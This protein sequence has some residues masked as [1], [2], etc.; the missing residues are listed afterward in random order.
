MAVTLKENQFT[1]T[2]ETTKKA[3][4][5]VKD[6]LN[7]QADH[8]RKRY[9]VDLVGIVSLAAELQTTNQTL[10]KWMCDNDVPLRDFT[11]ARAVRNQ[12]FLNSIHNNRDEILR[13]RTEEK[14]K[15]LAIAEALEVSPKAVG[16]VLL[17]ANLS[18]PLHKRPPKQPPERKP[19]RGL[20]R[21]YSFRTEV[22]AAIEEGMTVRQLAERFRVSEN[23]VSNWLRETGLQTCPA[24]KMQKR[25]V[26]LWNTTDMNMAAIAD[27]L[28]CS[29]TNVGVV[30]RKFG[31]VEQARPLGRP[32]GS[33]RGKRLPTLPHTAPQAAA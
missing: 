1:Q 32:P 19:A 28:S 21:L 12:A 7:Q 18:I 9:L 15:I 31:L 16:K 4:T 8:I 27:E 24:T 11:Q 14:M 10:R 33:I 17:D 6:R 26:E 2:E 22:E 25:I 29:R 13:L 20:A 3:E 23:S 30:L 5:P